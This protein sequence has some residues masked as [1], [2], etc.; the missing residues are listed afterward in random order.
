VSGDVAAN[1]VIQRVPRRSVEGPPSNEFATVA[2]EGFRVEGDWIAVVEPGG[3]GEATDA[4]AREV[5]AGEELI[6]VDV[7]H[8]VI[9]D[10]VVGHGVP[11]LPIPAR[12]VINGNPARVLKQATDVQAIAELQNRTHASRSNRL[13]STAEG[14]PL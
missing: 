8:V 7:E 5:A 2:G 6:L 9:T 4:H 13:Q 12:H 10:G 14:V 3:A 11:V 1:D